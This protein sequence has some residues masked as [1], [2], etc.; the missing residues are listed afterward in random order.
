MRCGGSEVLW[1]GDFGKVESRL[2]LDAVSDRIYPR[3]SL[4]HFDV[5]EGQI[6]KLLLGSTV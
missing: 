4:S 3:P 1:W 2:W 5:R 6:G